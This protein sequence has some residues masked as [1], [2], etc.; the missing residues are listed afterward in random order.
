MRILNQERDV[1]DGARGVSTLIIL[2]FG[3]KK[4]GGW[5][6]CEHEKGWREDPLIQPFVNVYS[7]SCSKLE[8][9]RRAFGQRLASSLEIYPQWPG[10]LRWCCTREARELLGDEKER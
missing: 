1:Q 8:M 2:Y 6:A 9:P 5:I 10:R 7:K 4:T 3:C